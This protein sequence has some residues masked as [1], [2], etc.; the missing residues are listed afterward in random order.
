MKTIGSMIKEANRINLGFPELSLLSKVHRNAEEWMDRANV[1]LRSKI[2]LVELESLVETGE[3]MPLGLTTTLEKLKSRFKQACEWIMEL[4]EQVP[5]PLESVS[6]SGCNL[7]AGNRAEWLLRMRQVLQNG[8]D[9]DV[10]AALVTLSA[11]GS[12]LSVEINIWQLLQTAIDARN[13]S[14][15]AK[16][17][18]P[19]S[20]DQ[21]RRGKIEDIND[22]L[23]GSNAISSRANALTDGKCDW[24]LEYAKE[25]QSIVD[26]ADDWFER[27]STFLSCEVKIVNFVVY[28]QNVSFT[29]FSANSIAP[30]L[31]E[32]TGGF[33]VVVRYHMLN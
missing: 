28:F 30:F 23:D 26:E 1:A 19:S 14:Q 13:W 3:K 33:K 8:E 32:T 5:C 24:D 9:E 29:Y 21:F 10:A 22:H 27:V 11:E 6:P 18:V 15:K 4:K 2:S 25:L 17:W 31:P 12:R 20:G 7:D 16:R